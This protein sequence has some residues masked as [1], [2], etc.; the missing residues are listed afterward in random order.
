MSALNNH[1]EA[2]NKSDAKVSGFACA[3]SYW[4]CT[5]SNNQWK[6]NEEIPGKVEDSSFFKTLLSGFCE[7][8]CMILDELA[9]PLRRSWRL[10]EYLYA[11]DLESSRRFDNFRDV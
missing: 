11:V 10:F 2:F 9:T 3:H 1:T 8:V 5:F 4:I 7:G 6:L